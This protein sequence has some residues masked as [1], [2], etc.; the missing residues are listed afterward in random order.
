MIT[1]NSCECV[2]MGFID[3]L[4]SQLNPSTAIALSA[5]LLIALWFYQSIWQPFVH[6]RDGEP[7]LLSG[8]IPWWGCAGTFG[9]NPCEFV[10][11]MSKKHGQ[12]FTVVAAGTRVLLLCDYRYTKAVFKQSRLLSA[13]ELKLQMAGRVFGERVV[14]SER[15]L[16]DETRSSYTKYLAGQAVD[17]LSSSYQDV[18][19]GVLC[20]P[21]IDGCDV[22]RHSAHDI[23]SDFEIAPCDS[24]WKT[25]DL[26]QFVSVTGYAGAVDAIFGDGAYNPDSFEDYLKFDENFLLMLGGLPSWLPAISDSL[27]AR[28]RLVRHLAQKRKNMSSLMTFRR[29]QFTTSSGVD[30]E[31]LKGHNV[32]F[33]FGLV[34]NTSPAQFWTLLLLL[35]DREVMN[36]VKQEIEVV[37]GDHWTEEPTTR[38]LSRDP[39]ELRHQL[40]ALVK[41]DSVI[42]EMFRTCSAPLVGR[43]ALE[44]TT[45]ELADQKINIRKGDRVCLVTHTIHNDEAIYGDNTDEFQWD[46]YLTEDKVELRKFRD[47]GSGKPVQHYLLPFGGGVSM[48]PG[49][50]FARDE[51]KIYIATLLACFDL[52]E[53]DKNQQPPKFDFA[54][55]TIGVIPPDRGDGFTVRFR[56]KPSLA[57]E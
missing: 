15:I 51:I 34:A 54:R 3:G 55:S 49:R 27:H 44:D 38:H 23:E 57:A 7:P 8:S 19:R 56:R 28:E 36:E 33:L 46:R 16:E 22:P 45:L 2:A 29:E 1:G 26:S 9:A 14:S 37:M 6:R 53:F 20:L 13:S 18:L 10:R 21:Q 5:S 35:K 41:L 42:N 24:E 40:T 12:A 25:I 4:V 31:D 11:D 50:H 32:G 39:N 48:C 17:E 30:S 47:L 43:V 52:E